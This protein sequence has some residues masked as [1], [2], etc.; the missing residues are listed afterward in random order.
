MK[1]I[2]LIGGGGHCK[3]VIDVIEQEKKYKIAG[4]IDNEKQVGDKILGYP[5]IGCDDDLEELYKA[6]KIA[7]ITVGQIKS[8]NIRI[9]LFKILK[10]IGYTLPTIISPL[11]YVSRYASVGEGTIIM[12]HALINASVKIGQNCIINTKALVEHDAVIENNCHISTGAVVNGGTIVKENSF[13]GSNA[14]SKEYIEVS[15]FIKA[16]SIVK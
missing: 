2:L 12:H 11:S 14:T 13:Y 4:I 7:F 9:R 5:V 1:E 10:E 8:P 3:S 6:Y 16:G 15:G